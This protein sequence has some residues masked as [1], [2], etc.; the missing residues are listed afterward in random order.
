MKMLIILILALS[1]TTIGFATDDA[2]QPNVEKYCVAA[3][4][5]ENVK[6]ILLNNIDQ[7][8]YQILTS[9]LRAEGVEPVS[10]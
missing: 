7:K 6:I 5:N 3:I 4:D 10:C 8:M 9:R 1:L 2:P